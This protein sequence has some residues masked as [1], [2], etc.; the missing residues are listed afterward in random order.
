MLEI[1]EMGGGCRVG[2][3]KSLSI[4]FQTKF[5]KINKKKAQDESRYGKDSSVL[6]SV[7]SLQSNL[8]LY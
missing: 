8:F 5:L 7:T 2:R 4:N 6:T 3:S 1:L